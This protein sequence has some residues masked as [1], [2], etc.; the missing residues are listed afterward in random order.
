MK[1][2]HRFH[3]QTLIRYSFVL[4]TAGLIVGAA[5]KVD[6][7]TALA[8]PGVAQADD[9]KTIENDSD[10]ERIFSGPQP[11]EKITPFKVLRVKDDQPKEL[12]IVKETEGTTLICFVHK[13]SGDDRIL[14]GLPLVDFYASRQ[15]ELTSHFVLLSD[16]RAK[17]LKMLR[18]WSRGS[19]FKTSLVSLS[20]DGAEGPG[21]YGLNRNVAMTVL[22][23]KGDK[24][25]N[26]LT[27][28]DP[29]AR[30]LQTIM[31]AVAIAL[32]KPKPTLAKVQQELRAE[33]QR[34]AEKRIKSS[35]VFKI[36]PNEELGRIMFG[37]VNGRGNQTLNAKRR[38]QQL[39]DWAGDNKERQSA[40][41]KYCKAVL[42]GD[43]QLNQY[44][45]AAVQKLAGE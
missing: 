34:Q 12:E 33:R 45:Q 31:V 40:L 26:N 14:Y 17:M 37:M 13:L 39:L 24:V 3:R 6:P 35:P 28:E 5:P 8:T 16:D 21:D 30:D 38:S 11:G 44:S 7:A 27:L 10:Q 1:R 23:A 25:V 20:V 15:K 2:S 22:V 29:N 42:A 32:G 41:K 4:A 43:F 18:G 19:L 36:A 9:E